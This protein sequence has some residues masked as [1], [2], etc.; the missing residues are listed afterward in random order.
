MKRRL[1][2]IVLALLA[3]SACLS[4]QILD[5][6]VASVNGKPVLLSRVDEQARM[7][8]LLQGADPAAISAQDRAIALDRLINQMLVREQITRAGFAASDSAV[9]ARMAEI[10]QALNAASDQGWKLTLEHYGLTDGL[11]RKYVRAEVDEMQFVEARF[12]PTIKLAPGEVDDFYRN[13]YLP[14]LRARGAREVPIS[15]VRSQIEQIVTERDITK[16]MATWLQALRAQNNVRTWV[17][18]TPEPQ[19]APEQ[20]APGA[21][22]HP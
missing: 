20:R 4:G 17:T 2:F 11:V 10:A 19:A 15:D 16:A 12:K 21:P 9:E 13:E 6:V 3:G 22:N 5:R 1:P 18:F 8:A 7:A 14:K